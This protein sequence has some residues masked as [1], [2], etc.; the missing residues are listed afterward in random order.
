MIRKIAYDMRND[1]ESWNG[2]GYLNSQNPTS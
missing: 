2:L 1:P